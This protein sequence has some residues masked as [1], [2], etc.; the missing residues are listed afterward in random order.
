[1]LDHTTYLD[2]CSTTPLRQE[3]LVAMMDSFACE[4]GNPSSL[5]ERGRSAKK[6]L[7]SAREMVASA[8]GAQ[9]KE[10]FFTASGTEANNLAILGMLK[11]LK[12]SPKHVITTQIEHPSVLECFRELQRKGTEVTY[13]PVSH[14]GV[15]RLEDLQYALRNETCLVSIMMANNEVG[16]LQPVAEAA[17]LCKQHKITFHTDAVQAVGK[18]PVNVRDLGVDMLSFSPH[19]M[20]GPKGVGVLYVNR[21]TRVKPILFGGG[22]ERGLR[23]A[24]ENVPAIDGSAVAVRLAIDEMASEMVRLRDLRDKLLS[25]LIHNVPEII[26]TSGNAHTL[27]HVLNICVADVLGEALL[28]NLDRMGFHVSAGSACSSANAEPS[29]VL[30]AMQVDPRYIHGSVRISLGRNTT[31]TDIHRFAD[32]FHT[33]VAEL[34]TMITV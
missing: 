33:V 4:F 31:E 10:I 6:R 25:R 5:H 34:R 18:V 23:S 29:H 7:E 15:V 30:V 26:I 11:R 21:H 20:Y 27:P 9:P 19:K 12:Q 22:Q 14:E 1:M 8:I 32:A 16:T 13:L 24:T 28:L 2:Y 17:A 3:A